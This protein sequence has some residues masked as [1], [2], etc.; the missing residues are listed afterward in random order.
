M[1]TVFRLHNSGT[2]NSGWFQS[3]PLTPDDINTIVSKGDEAATSIPSPFAQMALVKTAFDYLSRPGVPLHYDSKKQNDKAMHQLV[4]DALDVAQ[5]FYEYETFSQHFQIFSWNVAN[6][7]QRLSGDGNQNHKALADTLSVFWNSDA[8]LFKFNCARDIYF[9]MT[10]SNKLIGATSPITMFMAAPDV[11]ANLTGIP[12][13]NCANDVLFDDEFFSLDQRESSFVEYMYTL[14]AQPNFANLFPSLNSYLLKIKNASGLLPGQLANSIAQIRPSDINKYSPSLVQGIIGNQ[15]NASGINIGQRVFNQQTL[16][17]ESGFVILPDYPIQGVLPLVLPDKPFNYPWDYTAN[18]NPWNPN[19]QVDPNAPRTEL[20]NSGLP[21]PWL[22]A[23]DFL[24]DKIVRLPY[25]VDSNYYLTGTRNDD[26]YLL[27]LKPKFFEFFTPQSARHLTITPLLAGGVEVSLS[28]PVRNGNITF[29][30]RYLIS[31]VVDMNV[32]VAIMP[33]MKTQH[34]QL[35]Y[36]VAIHDDRFEKAH[37]ID[38]QCFNAG[39]AVTPVSSVVRMTGNQ[40]DVKSVFYRLPSF[41]ALQIS[42]DDLG[43]NGFVV[44]L[45]PVHNGNRPISFAID[46]GT[47]NTHI[48]YRIGAN[49]ECGLEIS[50]DNALWRSLMAAGTGDGRQDAVDKL[51]DSEL[52]PRTVPYEVNANNTHEFPFRTAVAYNL[53][54]DFAHQISTFLDVN[55]FMLFEKKSQNQ[56]YQSQPNLKWSNYNNAQDTV[57]VEKYIESLLYIALYKAISMDCNPAH[58]LVTWFYPISMDTFEQGI[59]RHA[60]AT[61]F[62]RVFSTANPN[63]LTDI[64]ES[65]APYLYYRAANPGKSLSVD[66][67]G[68]ST[69][70][71][72]FDNAANTP[73]FLSSFRFAGNAIY[74]DGFDDERY[75]RDISNNGYYKAFLDDLETCIEGDQNL[76]DIL[77]VIK[78]T[79]SSANF[80]N[81][82]FSLESNAN[83]NFNYISKL[84]QHRTLK[85]PFLL[86]YGAIV[87]YAAKLIALLPN[88]NKPDNIIF[89]G[90]AS[91]SLRVLDSNQDLH[92]IGEFFDFIMNKVFYSE[93]GR[94]NVALDAD[95]KKVT[96]KGAFRNNNVVFNQ[97]Q[98]LFWIGGKSNE[99]GAVLNEDVPGPLPRY[100]QAD[101]VVFNEIKQSIMEFYA[102]IDS[103]KSTHNINSLFGI[104]DT[105]YNVFKNIRNNH[106]ADYIEQGIAA[107]HRRDD[108]RIEET[109]FFMPF[110][111]MLNDL[112]N[113]LA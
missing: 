62:A 3:Q 71:A 48:E 112:G 29:A 32:H 73:D 45:M 102:I 74:G 97:T 113:L 111:A 53:T 2:V 103:Y 21:Y 19:W 84:Q 67:G 77:D 13:L 93:N 44:P 79:R 20:P 23:S 27:P 54:T 56:N 9:I 31:E 16:Q 76:K 89:S 50:S 40:N 110:V 1:S 30:K 80:S 81:F 42:V 109:F 37:N 90:N 78:Q 55:P 4:S 52:F 8:P 85:M 105:C 22:S 107:Y 5:L 39:T 26:S 18:G 104:D 60:W 46:F 59:F 94:I 47:T 12:A 92:V 43:V 25:K 63:N 86:F 57:L 15:C 98:K 36:T 106:I 35:D 70:I 95:P 72:L 66:I 100:N 24:E 108:E 38:I 87:Y 61:A 11:R 91:K 51:F 49:A 69:D 10:K 7:F 41:D 82:M 28:I 34:I 99:W 88:P 96:C 101:S 65:V 33:F 64:P 58:A 17:N 75:R 83:L 68:G 14:Q 6:G